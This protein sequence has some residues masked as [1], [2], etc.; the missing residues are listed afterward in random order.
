MMK[1]KFALLLAIS[2]TIILTNTQP[3]SA[4]ASLLNEKLSNT[5]I[6]NRFS[7]YEDDQ[8][9]TVLIELEEN[10]L[11]ENFNYLL[12]NQRL[13]SRMRSSDYNN[14]K[15]YAVSDNGEENRDLIEQQQMR[16]VNQIEEIADEEDVEIIR[17]YTDIANIVVATVKVKDLEAVADLKDVKSISPSVTY[18]RPDGEIADV[19]IR[20][21]S[22]LVNAD[23]LEYKG[24][25]MVVAILDT[26]CD[27]AHEA[28][29]KELT[30]PKL[31]MEKLSSLLAEKEFIAEKYEEG[32]A[33]DADLV[34]IN[35]KIPFV[36]D[37][38]DHD[39]NINPTKESLLLGNNHGNHVAGIIGADS[40]KVQGIVPNAQLVMMKVFPDAEEG[41]QDYVILDALQDC[42]NLGVDVI[43][44]SLGSQDGYSNEESYVCTEIIYQLESAGVCII[45][46]AGNNNSS[47]DIYYNE[48]VLT[49]HPDT[50]R[51]GSPSTGISVLSVASYENS[52]HVSTELT[53]PSGEKIYCNDSSPLKEKNFTTLNEYGSL[54][55]VFVKNYGE[56]EDYAELDVSGKIAVVS[57]GKI[58]FSE[59]VEYAYN[60]GAIGLI[61][62]NNENNIA[63]M[64]ID[65]YYIPAVMI[66]S[67]DGE[68]IKEE[69]NHT[70]TVAEAFVEN[71]K[72]DSMSTFSSWG[73]TPDLSLKPEI[74]GVGGNI[75]STVPFNEYGN[76]S[77]TSMSAPQIAGVTAA[78]LQY[79]ETNK[80]GKFATLDLTT[81]NKS[82]L[83]YQLLMSTAK[84]V[85]TTGYTKTG[86]EI[87]I[88]Y[89]P[90]KQGAGLADAKVA[91]ETGAYLYGDEDS[92]ERPLMNLG[93]DPGKSGVFSGSFHIRN[94]SGETI[95][96]TL[97]P[98]VMTET[99][100]KETNY[101]W[102]MQTPTKLDAITSINIRQGEGSVS[103]NNY[104]ESDNPGEY[105]IGGLVEEIEVS[106]ATITVNP[107]A[108]AEIV[109]NIRLT[110]DDKEY[111][112]QYFENGEFV[113][114]FLS[115]VKNDESNEHLGLPFM[116]FFGDWTDAPIFDQNIYDYCAED[117]R[118]LPVMYDSV[119]NF[120]LSGLMTS[121]KIN[122][123]TYY[124]YLGQ[125]IM[126][127]KNADYDAAK[128]CIAF[129][130]NGDNHNDNLL[131]LYYSLRN[132]R[133]ISYTIKDEAGTLLY[134][135]TKRYGRKSSYDNINGYYNANFDTLE[136][137]GTGINS[138]PL[139]NNTRV[140]LEVAAH[141]DYRLE[142]E[143]VCDTV[144]LPIV[145]DYEKPMIKDI[146]VNYDNNEAIITVTDNQYL[147][148]FLLSNEEADAGYIEIWGTEDTSDEKTVV[149]NYLEDYDDYYLEVCDYAGNILSV[150]FNINDFQNLLPAKP[151]VSPTPYIIN[152]AVDIIPV[153]PSLPQEPEVPQ[154]PETP[155]EPTSTPTLI[156]TP[157]QEPTDVDN[158]PQKSIIYD[159]NT[160]Y[161]KR[162][163][164][165]DIKTY[166]ANGENLVLDYFDDNRLKYEWRFDAQDY[167]PGMK[168]S[169]INTQV[170]IKIGDESEHKNGV[171]ISCAQ[172]GK[173]P[174]EARLKL[175]LS[176]KYKPGQ[177]LYLY[178]KGDD[179]LLC[180]PNSKYVVDKDGY[181]SLNIAQ[182]GNYVLLEKAAASG[183]KRSVINQ[184]KVG[185]KLTLEA[186]STKNINVKLPATLTRV[187]SL[188]QFDVKV[189]QAAYGARVTYKS[190]NPNVASVSK[191]GKVNAKKKG[192][193]E[194]TI[195]ITLSNGIKK[196]FK[197]MINVK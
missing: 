182:G 13:N 173:M 156:P 176:D 78:V 88:P 132:A 145:I 197:T 177:K 148:T 76:M 134:E 111:L 62:C 2:M 154:E 162:V 34:Y 195:Q 69:E 131:W 59:K 10:S 151:T 143:S 95:T 110:E 33:T 102:I 167:Q 86:E 135:Q 29:S 172:I 106:G 68:K 114:G 190:S 20:S 46:S 57:R 4:N 155:Q 44:L 164:A 139:P 18:N 194:I 14:F 83:A 91:I 5:Y 123:Q 9:V 31:T 153:G 101:N 58:S 149:F 179:K 55:Y 100:G 81:P 192:K 119:Q 113:E 23:Q 115:L 61:V 53:L 137:D 3:I 189:S 161:S 121:K 146:Q 118:T 116:G 147:N 66:S 98:Y 54:Q 90:R 75:Y 52:I 124:T 165:T 150:D 51:V 92:N 125:S 39:C 45:A 67:G 63:S 38:A 15:A 136:W 104:H 84:P 120:G 184:V 109:F 108:D 138:V 96:Y 127:E 82:K 22:D 6:N 159:L 181:V 178:I 168:L 72:R 169:G 170:Q 186:K 188:K 171:E 60:H 196:K 193:A 191:N 144:V 133:Y 50:A 122:N 89:S 47:E 16:V 166:L 103:V 64:G 26:G 152:P 130:P 24:D 25:Q 70:F 105:T 79:I 99:V 180:V 28:F 160:E 49:T 35:S 183:Q 43:N 174:L 93:D 141:V 73:C 142:D 74:T 7:Q 12:N 77:G 175:D 112:Q 140:N 17:Q 157:V 30:N 97:K 187:K 48:R 107:Y 36:Y 40:D 117:N 11:L 27:V 126:L 163:K 56:Y 1:R 71:E 42:L 129:S 19:Y 94:L 85:F 41:A 21:G 80:E 128:K 185:K 37:Y 8:K 158:E 32:L 65:N 87:S